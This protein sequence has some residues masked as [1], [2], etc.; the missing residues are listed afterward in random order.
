[1]VSREEIFWAYRFILGRDPEG[2]TAY[3]AHRGHPDWAAMRDAILQSP[4]ARQNVARIVC[5]PPAAFD[6]FRRLLVFL[7]IEKTGG[8]SLHH[9][10]TSREEI[11]V[12]PNRLAHIP[13]LTLGFLNQYDC[14]S[15]HFTYQEALALPRHPKC[16]VTMLRNP[17]DRLISFYR[18][19]RAHGEESDN[20]VAR[21]AVAHSAVDFFRHPEIIGS[22]RVFN[23]YVHNLVG[24]PAH[25]QRCTA[26]AMEEATLRSLD[27]LAS[28]DAVGIV[29]R[30]GESE[31]LFRAVVDPAMPPVAR[32]NRTDQRDEE[33]G[34]RRVEPVPLTP[35]L[36]EAIEP[37]I[38]Y[39]RVIYRH[40]NSLLSTRLTDL[41]T[42]RGGSRRVRHLLRRLARA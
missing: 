3:R 12:S 18:F 11:A 2:E 8:T 1:V 38:A 27:I 16:I 6:Y 30:M 41:G 13:S 26:E 5:E 23:S 32:L 37:L 19:H 4:E 17:A 25:P 35:E 29:E 22:H 14:I 21:I 28:L 42:G 9:A 7:H 40:A 15:G 39:D 31:R 34:F 33:D 24:L 20:P 36:S 10:L